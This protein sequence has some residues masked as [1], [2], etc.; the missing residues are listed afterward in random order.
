MICLGTRVAGRRQDAP[1]EADDA[2]REE[3]GEPPGGERAPVV[4]ADDDPARAD[5]VEEPIVVVRDR[6]EAVGL[7]LGGLRRAAVAELGGAQD[8]VAAG[9][10]GDDFCEREARGRS[11]LSRR[12]LRRRA[13]E[14]GD[15][16]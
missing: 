9:G 11:G 14:A 8:A 16:R 3:V 12:W 6:L 10:E 2:V 15:A 4:P 7:D 1:R 13:T 5:R